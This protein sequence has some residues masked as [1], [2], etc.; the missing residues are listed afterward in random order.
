MRWRPRCIGWYDDKYEQ[1][2]EVSCKFQKECAHELM[3]KT[4]NQRV[5]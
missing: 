3:M 2:D 5:L 4:I 1:C